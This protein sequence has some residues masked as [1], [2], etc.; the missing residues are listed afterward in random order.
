MV[1][2]TKKYTTPAFFTHIN[3]CSMK[4]FLFLL[5]PTLA[6]A[7]PSIKKSETF[8]F[9][10]RHRDVIQSH[11]LFHTGVDN[12]II[13]V[14]SGSYQ[15]PG[16]MGPETRYLISADVFSQDLERITSNTPQKIKTPDNDKPDYFYAVDFGGPNLIFSEHKKKDQ[17]M[18]IYR[19]TVAANGKIGPLKLVDVYHVR[20]APRDSRQEL[21]VNADSSMMLLLFKPGTSAQS[22]PIAYMVLDKDWKVV[23]KGVLPMPNTEASLLL[24]NA[25]L[26]MDGSIWMP[27][28]MQ[29]RQGKTGLKQE[30]WVWRNSE[31]Q[32]IRINAALK[33]ELLVTDMTLVQTRSD[34]FIHAGGT[35]ATSNKKAQKGMFNPAV[36][37][38]DDRPAIGSYYLK[39]DAA[40]ATIKTP[41]SAYFQETTNQVWKAKYAPINKDEGIDALRSRILRPQ[42]DGSVWLTID[43]Y[44]INSP[45]S[46]A[47]KTIT[48]DAT[49]R[50]GPSILVHF[51][52][53]GKVTREAVVLKR[54]SSLT[55]SGIGYVL[56]NHQESLTLFYNDKDSNIDEPPQRVP[57]VGS[58][59]I[60]DHAGIPMGF[61]DVCVASWSIENN[62]ATS[63]SQKLFYC[64]EA[65]YWLN[66]DVVLQVSPTRYFIAG[67]GRDGKAGLIRVD[68]GE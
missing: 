7:Q 28:W 56:I 14:Y 35:F 27:V 45:S 26:D 48:L 57:D 4:S 68:L 39:I 2:L 47:F 67:N 59:N 53:D 25:L 22:D 61:R 21:V 37:H 30:I 60:A 58:A 41:Y 16:L 49:A 23:R 63:K 46:S 33:P 19:S 54:A 18:K 15:V 5:L 8:L 38:N 11:A 64:K 36:P 32:P 10:S 42:T 12:Q 9:E 43:E 62:Q 13:M 52:P 55:N 50:C 51:G 66:P 34:K 65:G 1:N 20:K 29:E 3:F 44:Y 40:T 6:I 31:D 17:E 24:G